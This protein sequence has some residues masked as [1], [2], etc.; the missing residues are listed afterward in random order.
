MEDK[1][2]WFMGIDWASEAHHICL[3]DAQGKGPP[4]RLEIGITAQGGA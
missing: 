1:L 4:F 3:S 2:N